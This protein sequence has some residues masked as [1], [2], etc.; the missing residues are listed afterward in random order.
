M[1]F[2][3]SAEPLPG[4]LLME[5]L[6]MN[7]FLAVARYENI[8]RASEKLHISPGALSKAVSRLEEELGKKLFTRE[9]RNIRLTDSGNLL[10]Q[11]ASEIVQL[12]E[13]SKLEIVGH[14]GSIHAVI[15]GPEILLSQ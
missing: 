12:E 4:G 6:E 1:V 10:V 3:L 13:L 9:G 7:Y 11:R 8:H 15:A 5:I 2:P 14:K